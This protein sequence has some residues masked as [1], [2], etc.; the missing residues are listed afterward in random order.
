[1]ST[2]FSECLVASD[3]EDLDPS[4]PDIRTARRVTPSPRPQLGR[5]G[6]VLL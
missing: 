5:A 4:H 2:R 3:L 6:I 1:M